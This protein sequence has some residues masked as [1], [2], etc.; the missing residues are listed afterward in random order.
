MLLNKV[1]P[2]KAYKEHIND[3][4]NEYGEQFH[5][6]KADNSICPKKKWVY[7]LYYQIFRKEYGQK[8]EIGMLNTLDSEVDDYNKKCNDTCA[9]FEMDGNDYYVVIVTPEMKRIHMGIPQSA[10]VLFVD[11]TGTV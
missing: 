6:I 9:A 1:N 2:H 8:G 3:L 5:F 4:K 10:E 7:D 11:S